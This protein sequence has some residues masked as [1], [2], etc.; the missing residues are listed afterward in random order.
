MS[1][2]EK[3]FEL[4]RTVLRF[5]VF[6]ITGNLYRI[7]LDIN[8]IEKRLLITAF[9]FDVPSDLELELL[10]DI[11]TNS[12]AHIPDFFVESKTE[13]ISNHKNEE[14]HDFIIFA[15]YEDY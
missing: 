11:V 14:R 2:D 13:L 12:K 15:V 5:L 9:Y 8:F 7:Y 6:K 4:Y 3:K 1:E 10:D